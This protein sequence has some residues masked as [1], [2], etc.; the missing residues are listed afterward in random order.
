[1]VAALLA[2]NAESAVSAAASKHRVSNE[3][4]AFTI[5]HEF[6]IARLMDEQNR[7]EPAIRPAECEPGAD[8]PH[9]GTAALLHMPQNATAHLIRKLLIG[10]HQTVHELVVAERAPDDI[11]RQAHPQQQGDDQDV[12][13]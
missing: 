11:G 2:R 4:E 8:A 7:N 5:A 1:M 3:L 6:L 10:G 13:E 12:A 9:I